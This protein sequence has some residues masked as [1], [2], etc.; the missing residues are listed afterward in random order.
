MSLPTRKY[1]EWMKEAGWTVISMDGGPIF[2]IELDDRFLTS[3]ARISQLPDQFVYRDSTAVGF[4]WH[5]KIITEIEPAFDKDMWLL[6]RERGN[7]VFRTQGR[8]QCWFYN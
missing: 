5:A 2:K 7:G 1:K 8:G 6:M 4:T 3:F